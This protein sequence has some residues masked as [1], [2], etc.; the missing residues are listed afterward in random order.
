MQRYRLKRTVQPTLEPITV[1]EALQHCR[2]DSNNEEAW[3]ESIIATAREWVEDHCNVTLLTTTWQMSLDAFPVRCQA[4]AL[5]RERIALP[6]CPVQSVSSI[7]YVDED[8][9]TQTVSAADYSLDNAS[10]IEASVGPVYDGEWPD[11][12]DQR[13]AV[14]VTYVAG[15]TLAANVPQAFRHAIRLLVGHW[16]ENREASLVGTISKEIEFSVMS[17]IEPRNLSPIG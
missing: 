5:D 9:T 8:G 7:T 15:H 14:V 16:N 6:R 13:N 10:N 1:A 11:T 12:R 4:P 17:L 2:A 3:F